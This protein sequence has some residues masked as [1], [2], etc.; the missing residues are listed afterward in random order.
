MKLA[1]EL[2]VI[3]PKIHVAHGLCFVG[4]HPRSRMDT[5]YM[6]LVTGTTATKNKARKWHRWLHNKPQCRNSPN[7]TRN[8]SSV[9]NDCTSPSTQSNGCNVIRYRP[10]PYPA[11]QADG[12]KTL[13]PQRGKREK[14]REKEREERE[15]T[16]HLWLMSLT[17]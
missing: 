16:V 8:G 3:P 17:S 2:H 6:V 10:R 1:G 11:K 14:E 15:A 12:Y 13:R 5:V 9:R 4:E 7:A